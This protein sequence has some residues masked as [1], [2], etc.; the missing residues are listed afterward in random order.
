[1]HNANRADPN[2]MGQANLSSLMLAATSLTSKLTSHFD[3]LA[4][5]RWPDRMTHSEEASRGAQ[6]ATPTD[7]EL[8]GLDQRRGFTGSAEPQRFRIQQ[9]FYRERIMNFEY[10]D[11][12]GFDAGLIKCRL[13][14]LRSQGSIDAHPSAV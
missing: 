1:M 4:R 8:A 9:L 14:G 6:R 10:V 7:I 3:D 2:H 12:G 11:V 13:T 5:A